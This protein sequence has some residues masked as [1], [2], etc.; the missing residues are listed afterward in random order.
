VTD[1]KDKQHFI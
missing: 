1:M